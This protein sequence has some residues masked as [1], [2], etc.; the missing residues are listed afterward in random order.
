MAPKKREK[1]IHN[2]S[3]KYFYHMCK[4]KTQKEEEEIPTTLKP[5]SMISLLEINYVPQTPIIE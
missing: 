3:L 1:N 4:D 2:K 5:I